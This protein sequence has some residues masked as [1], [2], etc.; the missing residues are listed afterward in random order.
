M[1]SGLVLLVLFVGL[2][3]VLGEYQQ[4]TQA[5]NEIIAIAGKCIRAAYRAG[6]CWR[7]VSQGIRVSRITTV[8]RL[9]GPWFQNI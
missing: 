6:L 7:Q 3:L 9:S 5:G 8:S 2:V 1:G 4:S